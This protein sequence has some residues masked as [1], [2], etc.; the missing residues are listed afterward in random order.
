MNKQK[1]P[2]T[3]ECD[4]EYFICSLISEEILKHGVQ[5]HQR[6]NVKSVDNYIFDRADYIIPGV[7][8]YFTHV[9]NTHQKDLQKA[10]RYVCSLNVKIPQILRVKKNSTQSAIVDIIGKNNINHVLSLAKAHQL[11]Q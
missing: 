2:Y 7:D 6:H 9:K 4:V 1:T 8:F 3:T 11:Q 10:G 5:I